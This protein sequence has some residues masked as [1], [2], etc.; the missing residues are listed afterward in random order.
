MLALFISSINGKHY[1]CD[2]SSEHICLINCANIDR[3]TITG[4]NVMTWDKQDIS[5]IPNG[6]IV[7]TSIINVLFSDDL[8]EICINKTYW[9]GNPRVS[10]GLSTIIL[11][12]GGSDSGLINDNPL[13]Q[14]ILD[15]SNP[16]IIYE[17]N[18]GSSL[19]I[20]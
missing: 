12:I 11:E 2:N 5:F 17:A 10:I 20:E 14:K 6:T 15:Q 13:C 7:S 3:S 19:S 1:L 4:S 16:V 8:N 18:G 9:K